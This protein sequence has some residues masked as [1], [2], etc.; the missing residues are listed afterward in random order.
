[1]RAHKLLVAVVSSLALAGCLLAAS[2][3]AERLFTSTAAGERGRVVV[4]VPAPG[5]YGVRVTITSPAARRAP[6]RV[7]VGGRTETLPAG[8]QRAGLHLRLAIRSHALSVQASG[9][10][11]PLRLSV[12]MRRLRALRPS[13]PKGTTS[14]SSGS[15]AHTPSPSGGS[16][17]DT[18][19]A[20]PLAPSNLT[21]PPPGPPGPPGDPSSWHS[22]FD[23][24]FNDSNLDTQNWSTGW[25]GSGVTA[26]VNSEE[27]ECYDPSQV[28][29]ANGE[30]DL[31]LIA[32]SESCGGQTRPY[33]SGLISTAGTFNFTYGFVEVRAWLPG[34]STVSDWP[35][36][37]TDG[38]S[39][40]ADGELD[41]AEGLGGLACW[42]FHDSQGAPGGC[43]PGSA[44]TG[45][46]HTFGA[47]WEPGSVTYYYDGNVVG[48]VTSGVTGSPMYLILDLA[49]DSEYGGPIQAPATL[50]VDYVRVW[51][52]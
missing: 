39:W 34:G 8:G 2:A 45:G 9:G 15:S 16:G 30:L 43:E 13:R 12:Q 50:R 35:A 27:L 14:G 49:V 48:S 17:T 3:S 42:H 18:L 21:P 36:L 23:D 22:V 40:P 10:V 19:L 38:Q 28:V 6:I 1:M 47:D 51:Q 29:E 24:E 7:R 25:Y 4:H 41:L 33:T 5:L 26:P 32:Q 52:Q 11:S 44:S 20:L 31:N 37:W 46:W